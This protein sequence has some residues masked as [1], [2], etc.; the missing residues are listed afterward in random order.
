MKGSK[1]LAFALASTLVA[2]V[3][4]TAG[5][6]PAAETT[7]GSTAG[8]SALSGSITVEGSDTLVNLAQAWA[9]TFGDENPGVM[10]SVKGGGSGNGIAAL[11]NGT[12][13]FANASRGMKDEE[14]AEATANGIDPV[15]HTVALDGIVIVVNPG[16]GLEGISRED[17]G[18]VY[19][20]EITNWKDLGGADKPIILIGRDTSSGT[21]EYFKEE[22]VGKDAEYAKSMRNLSSNQAQVDE[23]GGNDAAI[24]YV[25]IG[26]AEAAGSEVK[27]LKVDGVA[28]SVEA[29]L[30]GSY[31]LSRGLH[32]YSDGEPDGPLKAYLDWILSAA[33]Q[34]IVEDQGFVKVR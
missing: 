6:K 3:L 14:K 20:G 25:G 17:L 23:I 4:G 29:V 18:K 26:Y 24:G 22:V 12:V 19:R 11:I 9:E 32:M 5:C 2:G 8:G 31:P 27:L 15:E 1:W 30:D 33:G 21:Y 13:D 34:A 10:I 28:P 16:N 7:E